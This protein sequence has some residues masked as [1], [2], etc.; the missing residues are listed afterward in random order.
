M[1]SVE[2]CPHRD[3]RGAGGSPS[4]RLV[5]VLL[6]ANPPGSG[7]VGLD[8]CRACCAG[9]VP[10]RRRLG[11]VVASLVARAA[12]DVARA[13]GVPGCDVGW[14]VELRR[15]A[16]DHLRPVPAASSPGDRPR[17]E[18]QGR[19]GP[20][21]AIVIPCHDHGRFLG[22]AIESALAQTVPPAE[23]LVVDDA[24]S[25][26]TAE[27]ARRYESRGVMYRRVEFRS[28]YRARRVGLWATESEV[29]CFLDADD[30]LPADFLELGLPL[31]DR[32]E[33][34]IAYPDL[35]FFGER[36]GRRR[37]PD[38]DR[39]LLET[40]NYM[41]ASSLVRRRALEVADAFR[42]PDLPD[43]L[44]DWLVWRKVVDAGWSVVKH[45]GALLYRR[46]PAG[47]PSRSSLSFER[48]YFD[49][50]GLKYS[51][52]TIATP[53]SGR[54]ALWPAYRDWLASQ[55]WPRERS[56]LFLVDSSGDPRFGS[57]VRGFLASCDYPSTRYL[58]LNV[59]EPGLADRPRTEHATA[60][61]LAC[62]RIYN[63]IA[64]EVSTP[65]VLI[66]EDDILP[67]PGVIERL[68]RAM[69]QWTAAVAAPYR[70]RLFGDYVAW[71]DH[72]HHYA[73][74]EGVRTIG[75]CGFGCLLLRRAAFAG[76]TFHF[77]F[78]ES[79]WFD[80][81][82]CRRLR[83]AG[84]TIKIDWSQECAHVKNHEP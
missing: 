46:H 62:A 25:D 27:V 77:G 7:A 61:N 82:F 36:Q 28:V 65:F 78:A 1:R 74:G 9:P 48:S 72:T 68:L 66:V 64:R 60:V 56:Q 41:T 10:D 84:W 80:P 45:P 55:A 52:V 4:C 69:D 29:L 21:T 32:P 22:E 20:S 37:F 23:I 51:D 49:N 50:A 17:P 40:R 11:P 33:V 31:F 34:G 42:E 18:S 8:A 71:D 67:P 76:E 63:R 30:V 14:A 6:E 75:G 43:A 81:A 83:L 13:G 54:S 44:E 15:W 35:E 39:A 12:E 24:S 2:S 57:E 73:G 3:P 16:H 58:A 5:A 53:L 19:A 38:F 70:S 59:A 79:D 26:E 47:H